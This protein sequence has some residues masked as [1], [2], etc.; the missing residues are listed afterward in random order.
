MK[1]TPYMDDKDNSLLTEYSK[2]INELVNARRELARLNATLGERERF[3]SRILAMSP[4]VVYLYDMKNRA[5][6]FESRPLVSLL[7]FGDAERILEPEGGQ[8]IFDSHRS[9]L[10]AVDDGE[11]RSLEIQALHADGSPRWLRT[12]E[13]VFARDSAGLPDQILGVMDDVTLLKEREEALRKDS[14][15][16]PLTGLLNRR[17]FLAGAASLLESSSRQNT[18]C[19]LLFFDLD[20]FKAI[21]D[22]YGHAEGDAA[23]LLFAD[24]LRRTFRVSD[25]IGRYGGDEFVV[26]TSNV[27]LDKLTLLLERL[28]RAVQSLD[29]MKGRKFTLGWTSGYA[30]SEPEKNQNLDRLIADADAKMYEAKSRKSL[31]KNKIIS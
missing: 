2:L 14:T 25:I 19:L 20:D 9:A 22:D 1:G 21:N 10:V 23:L 29:R 26:F 3:L 16:D 12:K 7:G 8:E 24:G 5:Y 4:S 15:I 17:G 31:P 30:V 27:R 6:T 11:I 28:D 18:H 13:M